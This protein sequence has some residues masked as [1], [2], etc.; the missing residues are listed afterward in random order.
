ML[1]CRFD[2][3]AAAMLPPALMLIDADYR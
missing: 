2:A 1:R 3:A